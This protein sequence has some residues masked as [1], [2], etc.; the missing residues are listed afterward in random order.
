MNKT[1]VCLL[2]MVV[3]LGGCAQGNLGNTLKHTL[4]G[5]HYLAN[6]EFDQGAETF[7]AAVQKDPNSATANYYYGRF[8]LADKNSRQALPYLEQAARLDSGKAEY[9]FW[10]GVAYGENAMAA[11]ERESYLK[12]LALKKDHVPSLLYLGNNYLNAASY[13]KA[14][15]YYQRAL[16]I[17]PDN[18]QALYNRALIYRHLQRTPEERLAWRLYLDAYPSGPLAQRAAEHLN[19]LDDFS[20]RNHRLGRRTVTLKAITFAPFTA[21]LATS[22][23]A[24]LDVVG[25][26]VAN[27]PQGQ[28]NIVV[29]QKNNR[30]LAGQ[31]ARSIKVYLEKQ[32]PLLKKQQRIQLSWFDVAEK[33]RAFG[34]TIRHDESVTF[35]LEIVNKRKKPYGKTRSRK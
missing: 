30:V 7:Q 19:Q 15:K 34:R 5:Q 10:L 23:L 22:S 21:R 32:F 31:R 14:L 12:A 18:P 3:A 8:L 4:Q 1:T 2:I 13:Q 26:M 25:A 17:S 24:S 16:A 20:Y 6:K 9:H 35:F 28:L 11:R 29:Y 33:S 27:M